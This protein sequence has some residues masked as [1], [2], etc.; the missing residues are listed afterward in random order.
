ML[1]DL[2][3]NLVRGLLESYGAQEGLPGPASNLLGVL[4]LSLPDNTDGATQA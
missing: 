2:D 3:M 4:G 1:A